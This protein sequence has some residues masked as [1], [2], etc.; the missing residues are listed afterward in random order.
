MVGP[1][2]G[3]DG[4]AVPLGPAKEGVGVPPTVLFVDG[5]VVPPPPPV[6]LTVGELVAPLPTGC[7]VVGP[8]TGPP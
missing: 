1:D 7:S 3:A 4:A 5:A 8:D 2:T 6:P